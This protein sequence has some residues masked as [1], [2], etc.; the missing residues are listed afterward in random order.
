MR[1]KI[2]DKGR[3]KHILEAINALSAGK[4]DVTLSNL[5]DNLIVFYGFVKNVE[6]IGEAAYML[7]REFKDVHKEVD[8]AG[9][10]KMRHVLVHGYYKISREQIWN[11]IDYDMPE[12]KNWIEKYIQELENQEKNT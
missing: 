12:L 8:W 4:N 7:S 11:A 5:H 10:E 3:L 1:E 2:K 9:I 6:I